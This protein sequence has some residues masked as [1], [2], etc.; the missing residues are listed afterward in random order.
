MT[1]A[2]KSPISYRGPQAGH[3]AA[4]GAV[5]V[6]AQAAFMAGWLAAETWQ[7]PGYSPVTDTISDM[8]AA[9]APHVW[10][11]VTCFAIGGIGTFCFAVFGLRPALASAGKVAAAAPWLLACSALALGNSFPLIPCRL[12]DPGCT[13][14]DQLF[15]AGGLTDALVATIAFLVLASAPGPLVRR[16]KSVPRWHRAVPVMQVAR[17]VCPAC[18]LVLCL[19]SLTGAAQGLAERALTTTCVAWILALA[20]IAIAIA[21]EQSA[22][23]GALRSGG[24]P[25]PVPRIGSADP[26]PE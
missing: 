9:T 6:I 8:Q 3:L 4:W 13:A 26:G 10:F 21:R 20:I 24:K 1:I 2:P 15:S 12:A 19:S 23:R 25:D 5:G 17:V 7:G 14:H 18:F 22:G 16:L 11:P